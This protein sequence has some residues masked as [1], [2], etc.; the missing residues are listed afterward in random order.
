M[1]HSI[2]W[3]QPKYRSRKRF[4]PLV[5]VVILLL[6]I[7]FLWFS[8]IAHTP[9]PIRQGKLW[10][11]LHA[12]LEKHAPQCSSPDLRGASAGTPRFDAN[13]E[14][15]RRN[16]IVNSDDIQ[17]PLQIAHDGFVH[18]MQE[19]KSDRAY[20]P[21][22]KGIVSAA[23]GTYLPTFLVTLRVLRRTESKL[24]VELFVKDYAEYE[25]YICEIVLPQLNAKCIVLSDVLS[26]LDG[27]RSEYPI[28]HF[29][30]KSFAILFSS[31]EKLIW[32]DADILP[33]HDPAKLLNSE[34]FS[35]AGLVTWPDFWSNTASPLYFNVSR[36]PDLPLNARQA[37]EAGVF[38]VSKKTHYM[39]LLLSA[40]YNYH[41]PSYYYPLLDQGAPGEG[42]KDTFIQAATAL[43]E[44]FYTV[45]EPVVDLGH[46]DRWNQGIIGAAMLQAD[47]MED[48]ALTRR[49]KWR[50]KDPEVA[51]AARGFF[52]HSYSPEFN[53]GG[54]L[55]GEKSR[56]KDGNPTRLW[57][58][59]KEALERFGYDAEKVVWEEAKTVSCTLEH[60][61]D[62]WKSKSGLCEGVQKHWDAVFEDASAELPKFTTA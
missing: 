4:L 21:R 54:D 23:G 56:S 27:S 32:M 26:T 57:T 28:E 53:A 30:I 48:Y 9:L 62:A 17:Q 46:P 34:P 36:Q 12:L 39:T 11:N 2:M 29:Q 20:N 33:L 7:Y 51:K 49:G 52:I 31:F 42:D 10:R 61:F 47:P 14:S 18:D 43:G 45:S 15:S 1:S 22:T 13:D 19:L 8:P 25:P 6:N 58:D 37:T 40:Y 59:S 44:K 5:L 38:L 60:A 55:L 50:V 24:P 41:G 3:K 16:Y 35:S